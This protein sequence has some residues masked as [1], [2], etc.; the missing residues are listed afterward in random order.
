MDAVELSAKW[1]LFME[2]EGTV[3]EQEIY[4][5]LQNTAHLFDV[6]DGIHAKWSPEG[7]LGL[8]LVFDEDEA[9]SLFEAFRAAIEGVHEAGEAFACWTTS[10]MGL[11][12]QA[13]TQQWTEEMGD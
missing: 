6:I 13:L 7:T 8:L 2:E 12:R 10:L 1:T 4:D 9:E 11:L 3:L 5:D